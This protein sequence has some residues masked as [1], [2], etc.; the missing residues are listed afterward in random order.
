MFF[1]FRKSRL[2]PFALTMAAASMGERLL[3]IGL[4]D[5]GLATA[6]AA[7]VGLSGN[8]ALV[9]DNES[10]G[11]RARSAAARAGV[12]LDVHV[13][14]LHAMPFEN[15]S[16]DLIVV[17]AMRGLLASSEEVIPGGV[18]GEAY[19][20]LRPGGRGVVIESAR[21]GG[22]A[23]LLRAPTVDEKYMS[24]GGTESVLKAAG[25]HPVRTLAVR[26][27][28]RFTEGLKA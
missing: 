23:G 9:V 21:R 12:F 5:H 11:A 7:K 18:L 16:F 4:D 10:E 8:A 24:S 27:G 20:V 3:Q 15:A 25:F 6:L 2:E 17:H 28:Y 13:T 14:P 1:R 26:E 19:R 22:L